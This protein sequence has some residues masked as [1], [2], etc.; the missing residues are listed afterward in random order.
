MQLIE[1]L[2]WLG[3]PW[4]YHGQLPLQLGLPWL[5]ITKATYLCN[6]T[7]ATLSFPSNVAINLEELEDA[8]CYDLFFLDITLVSK[9]IMITYIF[10]L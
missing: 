3:L 9:V 7:A 1:W 10:H 4:G 8:S 2:P 6:L 5:V